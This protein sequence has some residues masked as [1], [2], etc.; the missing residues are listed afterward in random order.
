MVGRTV[1]GL[2]LLIYGYSRAVCIHQLYL[3]LP[4]RGPGVVSP[5][6]CI[7]PGHQS[8]FAPPGW[9]SDACRGSPNRNQWAVKTP[10][11]HQNIIIVAGVHNPRGGQLPLIGQAS[12]DLGILPRPGE[13]RQQHGR[14]QGK[15]GKNRQQFDDRE[16]VFDENDL[17]YAGYWGAVLTEISHA[18]SPELG[19]AG[20]LSILPAGVAGF[21]VIMN[22]PS[23]DGHPNVRRQKPAPWHCH[24]KLPE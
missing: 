13:R 6:F 1:E 3:R 2:I 12:D 22:Y 5:V 20:Q 4:D 14:E 23:T 19:S 15:H 8:A 10:V 17:A 7:L 9:S 18:K 11:G 21:A 24:A 16:T